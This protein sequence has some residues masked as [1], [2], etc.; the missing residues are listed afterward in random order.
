MVQAVSE[1]ADFVIVGGGSAGC[2][3]ANRLSATAKVI[4]LEAGPT[5]HRWDFRLHMPAALSQILTRDHYNWYYHSE[6]EPHLNH[7]RMYCPR[8]RVLG[9]SSSING[10]I[11][12]RGNPADFDG[13]ATNHDLPSWSYENC[14]PFFKKSE[15]Y[16]V[17][18]SDYRGQSGPMNLSQGE[19]SNPLFQAWLNSATSAG[20][21]VTDDFNGRQQEGLGAFDRTIHAGRRQ[22]TARAY[23]NAPN[24]N[25]T[26]H[27]RARVTRVLFDGD[28]AIGVEAIHRGKVKTIYASTE[29]IL[30]GGAINSPQLLMLSGIGDASDLAKVGIKPKIN[31]PNV[32]KNLQDHLEVYLQ[33]GCLKPV[34]IYP[35]T[36]WFRQ[37]FVGLQWYLKNTGPGANNHFETGAFLKS[38]NAVSYPDLQF[39]FLPIA[40]NY[41]GK[42]KHPGHG[43]QVHVG[44]MRPTSRGQVALN[45]PDPTASPTITFNY[46]ATDEDKQVMRQGI[47]MAREIIAQPA[48][49]E[50][51][52]SELRPGE[53]SITDEDI[54][55][56][57]AQYG[58]SA[59]HP[60]CTCKMGANAENSVVDSSAK[61][62]GVEK[63]RVVDASIM[64]E[65]TNANLNAPVIMMAEKI[66]HLILQK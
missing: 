15:T 27:T 17:Q 51:R 40:M 50:Y 38:S 9:G 30:S 56:F 2:V 45:S 52:G 47:R 26:V 3:L 62:H 23:L 59:Y 12:A 14:L 65:I 44:P 66:S 63:L 54:D 55:S 29:V 37:P 35:A 53:A 43:F 48:F 28:T 34:S 39:H 64:P 13:W 1:T 41:D 4:L 11:F 33:Y 36:Q 5:D 42:H 10:M 49:N 19:L 7:R 20:H 21:H 61:V 22:S 31:L 24:E 25:L 46:N 32:G 57:V 18:D 6:P 8:G 60:S 16:S 58:E